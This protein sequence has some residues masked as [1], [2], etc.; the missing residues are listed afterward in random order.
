MRALL[1]LLR[2]PLPPT[3]PPLL[4]S[5]AAPLSGEVDRQLAALLPWLR[6]PRLRDDSASEPRPPASLLLEKVG[7]DVGGSAR[8]PPRTRCEIVDPASRIDVVNESRKAGFRKRII[9][10][11]AATA[12]ITPTATIA[13]PA[14][15][16]DS[17]AAVDAGGGAGDALVVE[18]H[19]ADT[20]V[21]VEV[22]IVRFIQDAVALEDSEKLSD[23]ETEFEEKAVAENVDDADEPS[24]KL[25]DK[26]AVCDTD[27][28]G[29][30]LNC[31]CVVLG[32]CNGDSDPD[33]DPVPDTDADTVV[34][35]EAL[36]V[37]VPAPELDSEAEA[38][39]HA[40]VECDTLIV[41]V[42]LLDRVPEPDRDSVT[43]AEAEAV[44]AAELL[45]DCVSDLDRVTVTDA[46]V[47]LDC[48][49]EPD[50]VAWDSTPVRQKKTIHAIHI[51]RVVIR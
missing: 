34:A 27:I 1:P 18:V 10:P 28:V 19:E 44:E 30:K 3:R 6:R 33:R 7:G 17:A 26:L 45:L 9:R 35:C 14:L 48:V 20:E 39:A 37:C 5:S 25:S 11:M 51:N 13:A 50:C 16:I 47:D 23:T 2:P 31:V 36:I 49:P 32:D 41:C 4:R 43:E 24:L 15:N 42:V 40:V 29:V 12:R 8:R 38:E 22:V 21:E 46:V